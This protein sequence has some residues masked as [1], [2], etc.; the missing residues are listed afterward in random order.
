VALNALISV[1]RREFSR[2][3]RCAAH[4]ACGRTPPPQQ[5]AHA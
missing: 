1:V 5:P 4:T 3:C 2:R